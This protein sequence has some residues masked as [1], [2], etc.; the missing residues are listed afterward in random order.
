MSTLAP[1]VTVIAPWRIP[2]FY[3]RFQGRQDL[4]NYARE[5]S[6]PLPVTEKSPW[7]IDANLMH[8]SY[9]SGILEDPAAAPPS[10]LFQLTV[11]PEKAPDTADV[12][13]V[14]FERG[15]PVKVPLFGFC[16]TNLYL[17]ILQNLT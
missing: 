10:G 11:D 6:I 13:S 2:E 8:V 16:Y 17:D 15:V 4:F 14:Y 9:E 5:R 3:E 7:S 12:I 1:D